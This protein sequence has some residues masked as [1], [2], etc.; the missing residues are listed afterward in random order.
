[1]FNR[2]PAPELSLPSISPEMQHIYDAVHNHIK[3]KTS[4]ALMVTGVWGSG[5]T[6][7]LKNILFP[8][9]EQETGVKPVIVSLF[10]AMDKNSIAS[11]VFFAYLD[12]MAGDKK[13]STASISKIAHNFF[14]AVP[15]LKQYVDLNKLLASSDEDLFRFIPKEKLLIC[16]DDLERISDKINLEDFLGMVNELVEN[17]GNK[18]LIIANEDEIK[19]GIKFKEKIIEKTVHFS[20]DM[21]AIFNSIVVEYNNIKFKAYLLKQEAEIL[22]SLTADYENDRINKE[23]A[24]SFANIRSLKF[25]IEHFQIVF[26]LIDKNLDI[27]DTLVKRQLNGCW[28]FI[29][30]ITIEFK[31]PGNIS[32]TDKKNLN[33]S[34]G[35]ISFDKVKSLF[36]QPDEQ[37]E[38]TAADEWAYR[39]WFVDVYF[40]RLSEPYIFLPGVYDLITAGYSVDEAK[41]LADLDTGYNI[42]DGAVNPAHELLSRFT[43]NGYWHFTDAE[44]KPALQQLL[45]YAEDGKLEDPVSYLNAGVYLLGFSDILGISKDAIAK[46]LQT[47]LDSYLRT[48]KNNILIKTQLNM[49]AG[50]F[51]EPQLQD[52]I[53]YIKTGF[54]QRQAEEIKKEAQ[55]MESLFVYDLST[56]VKDLLPRN[57]N[58]RSPDKL[59]FDQIDTALIDQAVQ[60]WQPADIMDLTSYFKIRYLDPSFADRLTDEIPFLETLKDKLTGYQEPGKELSTHLYRSQLIPR[61][62]AC[63]AKLKSFLKDRDPETGQSH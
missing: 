44:F 17:K 29:L 16:F 58:M 5:K 7:Y 19:G 2:T 60:Q 37:E 40:K 53:G 30:A 21:A 34:A 4:G 41:F 27:N 51:E 56:F 12:K 46:K 62:E 35:P 31:K 32:F 42:T 54:K 6:Y 33:Q 59:L 52:L 23:L 48:S 9:L 50:H 13:L 10:G 15:K 8:K 45:T 20:N 25:A 3:M 22:R 49:V 11:K 28:L 38:A 63:I 47:G 36:N 14:E 1:M 39:T 43:T 18:V 61:L 55:G 57:P 26:E 24:V